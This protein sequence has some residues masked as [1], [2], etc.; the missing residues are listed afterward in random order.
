MDKPR[1]AT[2]KAA[3][4]FDPDFVDDDEEGACPIPD[5]DGEIYLRRDRHRTKGVSKRGG[6]K[7]SKPAR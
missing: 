2:T 3:P 6:K 4:Q 7:V 1:K 5:E